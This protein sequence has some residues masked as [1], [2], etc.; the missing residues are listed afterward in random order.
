MIYAIAQ[1]VVKIW[2]FNK[3]VVIS[4]SNIDIN[5]NI[6]PKRTQELASVIGINFALIL[7]KEFGG[8]HLNIPKK[9]KPDNKLVAYIGFDAYK[10]LCYYYAS[11]QIEI[12]LCEK[13][14]VQKRNM[15]IKNAIES[16]MTNAQIARQFGTTERN[17]RRVKNRINIE[18]DNPINMDLF[19]NV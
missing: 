2:M 14:L 19:D 15:E 6:L 12:D 13:L 16:G 10:K 17:I 4:M 7:V 9:P 3:Q 5:I 1:H 18:A 8:T 11:T